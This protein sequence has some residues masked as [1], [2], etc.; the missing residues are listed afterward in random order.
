MSTLSLWQRTELGKL[1]KDM[2]DLFDSLVRDFCSPVDLRLLRCEPDVRVVSEP[3]AV[4]VTAYVPGL[5]PATLKV[6]VSGQRLTLSGDKSEEFEESG[7]LEFSRQ[8]FASTVLLSCPVLAEQVSA[9]YA[10]GRLRIVLPRKRPGAVR[11]SVDET[12][13][14]EGMN[15]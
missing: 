1:K 8:S 2:D 10:D 11:V 14:E 12:K 13:H 5:D 9:S 15:E 4:V 7:S 3:D 6:L